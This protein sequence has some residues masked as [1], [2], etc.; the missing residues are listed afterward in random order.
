MEVIEMG[1]D[2]CIEDIEEME[3]DELLLVKE[4]IEYTIKKRRNNK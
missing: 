3:L 1:F 2:S 4:H